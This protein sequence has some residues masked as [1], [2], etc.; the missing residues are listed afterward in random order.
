LSEWCA[1]ED[2][3]PQALKSRFHRAY[4]RQCIKEGVLGKPGTQTRKTK[5][6]AEREEFLK[7]LADSGDMVTMNLPE[8]VQ[9]VMG[10]ADRQEHGG[11]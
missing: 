9:R 8:D 11:E 3:S 6:A 1:G 7:Q 10:Q 5:L 2:G 4:L